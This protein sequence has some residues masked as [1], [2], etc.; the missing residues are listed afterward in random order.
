VQWWSKPSIELK[1]KYKTLEKL[2]RIKS[3]KGNFTLNEKIEAL[4]LIRDLKD[5]KKNQGYLTLQIYSSS[6]VKYNS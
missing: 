6:Q 5:L 3:Y 4:E 2:N 1:Y